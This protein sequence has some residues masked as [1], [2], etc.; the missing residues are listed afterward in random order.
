M[1]IHP[2][3]IVSP[4]AHLGQ[5]V[6]VGP[7]T[8]I[9]DQVQIG[10]GCRIGPH[11]VIKSRVSIGPQCLLD[12][13][14]VLG[15]EPQDA[16]FQ[17]EESFVR[18][19]ARNVLRE[20]VTIHRATG[21]GQATVVGDDNFLMA[22]A[23][24]GH[25]TIVGNHT[26]IA[27]YAAI[28]GHVTIEDR[29]TVGGLVGIH[30]YTTVGTM[31]MIGGLTAVNRDVPPYVL[32]VG[33]PMQFHGINLVGLRRNGVPE[34]QRRALVDAFK[35]IYRSDL[36]TSEAIATLRAQGELSDIVRRFVD[37]IERIERG[38]R[39]RQNNPR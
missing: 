37:F 25:N 8:I 16:K 26:M 14:V 7:F 4:G 34:E 19:G 32:A 27:G 21:E 24:L 30:Q 38:A 20:Y 22:Y 10:D 39:G 36:N 6:E 13:G 9:E 23:H 18:I 28:A 1:R 35:L 33:V 29:A 2:S 3:A 11:C 5:G 12:V 17:G 31:A 15:S